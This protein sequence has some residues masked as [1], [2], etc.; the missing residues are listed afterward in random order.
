MTC[1]VCR[2][3]NVEQ[4]E[5][6]V[7]CGVSLKICKD[8]TLLPLKS[9]IGNGYQEILKRRGYSR[10]IAAVSTGF[11]ALDDRTCCG[12]GSFHSG[13]LVLLASASA[14]G[15]T[16]FAL[17]VSI[18]A[19]LEQQKKVAYF[20]MQTPKDMLALRFLALAAG[21]PVHNLSLD[22][23][24]EQE[25]VLINDAQQKLAASSIYIDDTKTLSAMELQS[26]ARNLQKQNGV[27]LIIVDSIQDMGSIG[28]ES[29]RYQVYSIIAR[30][31]HSL[32]RELQVPIMATIQLSY[33]AENRR[34]K[35]R[36]SFN[37][38]SDLNEYGELGQQ[39]DGVLFFH[40]EGVYHR[41]CCPH[42]ADCT[43]GQRYAAEVRYEIPRENM[44]FCWQP[45]FSQK[46]G[47]FEDNERMVSQKPQSNAELSAMHREYWLNNLFVH[48]SDEKLHQ[49]LNE[50]AQ[51]E[52]CNIYNGKTNALMDD[53][54]FAVIVDPK[55]VEKEEWELFLEARAE[56]DDHR[57]LCIVIGETDRAT[58]EKFS[59][60]AVDP[61]QSDYVQQVVDIIRRHRKAYWKC[62][63]QQRKSAACPLIADALLEQAASIVTI[64]NKENFDRPGYS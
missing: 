8:E 28:S 9:I 31:L 42:D 27:D 48:T 25:K 53:C 23:L 7:A 26:R 13:E 4:A 6:C 45:A 33:F 43:C 52:G 36:R 17:Q 14:M 61:M 30:C 24:T 15:K 60:T 34:L 44:F 38:V 54:C 3:N 62:K 10:K 5:H 29:S 55:L 18:H 1:F 19:A 35:E 50:Y 51:C 22:E 16:A 12:F 59:V 56:N 41:C 20:S 49:A 37:I 21:V 58:D 47:R 64:T 11:N 46:M 63:S 57:S 2:H 40:R 39:V 32:A